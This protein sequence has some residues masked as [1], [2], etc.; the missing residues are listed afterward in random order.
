[1]ESEFAKRQGVGSEERGGRVFLV[2][3]GRVYG[4]VLNGQCGRA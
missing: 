3:R 1:M 2:A 4:E